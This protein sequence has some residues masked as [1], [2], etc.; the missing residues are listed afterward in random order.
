MREMQKWRVFNDTMTID[1]HKHFRKKA[2][3]TDKIS[4]HQELF[5][6]MVYR[7]YSFC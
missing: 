6:M 3:V 7:P 2:V 1:S 5:I 4:I